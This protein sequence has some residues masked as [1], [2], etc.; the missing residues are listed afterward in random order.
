MA[1]N[2]RRIAAEPPLPDTVAQHRY[3]CCATH[4]IGRAQRATNHGSRAEHLKELARDG[5]A[6]EP[7]DLI[8]VA[9]R[10]RDGAI[11]GEEGYPLNGSDTSCELAGVI[12]P[13]GVVEGSVGRFSPE[14]HETVLIV[15]GKPAQQQRVGHREYRG[16]EPDPQSEREDGGQREARS[17]AEA[18]DAY[19]DVS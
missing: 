13:Q 12:Q 14:H 4:V 18:P 16:R 9:D 17:A 2:D 8:A 3:R 15:D 10:L 1:P 6:G 19:A 11:I 5:R 7:R